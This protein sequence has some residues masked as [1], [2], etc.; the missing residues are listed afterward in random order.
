MQLFHIVNVYFRQFFKTKKEQHQLGNAV[1]IHSQ[2]QTVH[3]KKKNT[4][5]QNWL[6]LW[7]TAHL[8]TAQ[9]G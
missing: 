6:S 5:V 8:F 7:K 3:R 2:Q 9:L 1:K 4:G